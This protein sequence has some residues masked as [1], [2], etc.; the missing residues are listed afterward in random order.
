MTGYFFLDWPIV[1]VSLFNT[2]SLIWLG[3]VVLFTAERRTLGLWLTGLS[4]LIGA[5][6][7]VSHTALVGL[8]F[9]ALTASAEVWWHLGW[10]PV[11]ALP[12]AWYLVTLWYSGFRAGFDSALGARHTPLVSLALALTLF[13]LALLFFDNPA[14]TFEQALHFQLASTLTLGGLPLLVVV[15][16]LYSLFCIL[17]ALDALFRPGPTTRLMG[18][19]ARQRARPWLV[20]TDLALVF[21]TLLVAGAMIW[22]VVASHSI[23][24]PPLP[25]S[26]AL[27]DLA[28]ASLI[29][30]ATLSVG[31]AV[32]AYEVFTGKTLPRRGLLRHWRR[33]I[34]LAAGFSLVV[35]FSLTSHLHPIYTVLLT[36]IV[37]ALFYGLLSWRSY[38]ERERY[39]HDLRPFVASQRLYDQLLSRADLP[40]ADLAAPFRALCE[41]VLGARSATLSVIGPLASLVGPALTYPDAP[42]ENLRLP[43][44][45][46]T[47]LA[48]PQTICLPL[49]P[50]RFAG[51]HWAVPLWSERG[52]IGFL[53]LGEKTDGSLYAQEE[54]EIARASGERF[55]D[56]LASA[57]LAQRLVALQR[58]RLAENQMLDHRARRVLHDEIL[59]RLHA[60]LL[61]LTSDP[62]EAQSLLTGA[63][64]QIA[65]LLRELPAAPA[66]HIARLGFVG[67]L[68]RLVADEFEKSFDSVKWEI[69][70]EVEQRAQT[71]PPLTAEVLYYAAREAIRNSARYARSETQPLHLRV[72]VRWDSGLQ[73]VIEDNGVGVNANSSS[74]GSGQ[75]LALHSAML[76]V[77]GGALTI[78]SQPGVFTRVGLTLPPGAGE[79]P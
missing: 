34:V 65:D 66:P 31:Q 1:T 52:P 72:S 39:I 6:F 25:P 13:T 33:A 62:A 45:E 53:L 40:E 37:I 36:A 19:L 56:T 58:Q 26:L 73:I 48:S 23:P 54:I 51:S 22:F 75:G 8:G 3:V 35:G 64:R 9:A 57:G 55:I 17:A 42:V 20:T 50:A 47:A 30:V 5:A 63:H 43:L 11:V 77:G 78:E 71:I 24:H 14:P 59:P 28:I 76:A 27:F 21:V 7:F 38:A 12:L 41:N 2:I 69:G 49:D 61:N 67:A 44:A 4:L 46:L 18:D 60:A 16:P 10:M 29:A 74:H 79:Q 68:Q 70:A 15:Y 32:V